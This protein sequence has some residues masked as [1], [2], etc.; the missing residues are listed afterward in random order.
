MGRREVLTIIAGTV[1]GAAALYGAVAL[2]MYGVQRSLLYRPDP[3]VPLPTEASLPEMGEVTLE[4][5]DGLRLA[6]WYHP[7]GT[8]EDGVQ[9]PTV[10]YFHGNA[11][12]RG[13]LGHKVRPYLDEGYGV[14]LPDYRGY[15]GNPGRPTED[16]LR[17][18][19]EAALA[20]LRGRGLD[21]ATDVIY[22]GE[23]L[24]SG[25]AVWLASE[26]PP[27]ALVLEAAFT[28]IPAVAA[29]QYPWL[30]TRV[31]TRDRF[32]SI[33]RIR[34]ITVPTLFLHGANDPLVPIDHS[35]QLFKASPA[36]KKHLHVFPDG[37][38]A[39]LYEQ[40]AGDM[41]LEWLADVDAEA[42]VPA[43]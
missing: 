25:V 12:N 22:H 41:I 2:G 11:G 20:Y 1:G 9:R 14:L 18:D 40:G 30:P 8:A 6:A 34:R 23:S 13:W 21:P 15:G 32:T 37:L 35:R 26:H 31:A 42:R 28:S 7:A 43:P 5:A 19:A 10:I 36:E 33:R 16:G 29:L 24:G 39:D 17:A 3:S 27:K 38:H 4:T